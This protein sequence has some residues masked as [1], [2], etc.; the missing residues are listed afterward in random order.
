MTRRRG[1]GKR[2]R[3]L[4]GDFRQL[5]VIGSL[6]LVAVVLQTTVLSRLG[7]PGATRTWLW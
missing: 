5:V 1:C 2:K 7:L 3:E 6:L 4:V